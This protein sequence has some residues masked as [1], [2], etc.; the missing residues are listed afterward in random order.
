MSVVLRTSSQVPAQIG[1]GWWTVF[2]GTPEPKLD[3]AHRVRDEGTALHQGFTESLPDWRSLAKQMDGLQGQYWGH[4]PSVAPNP[5]DFGLMMAWS[6]LVQRWAVL[7]ET[8]LVV[9]DDPWMFRHFSTLP[10]VMA[11]DPPPL[12]VPRLRQ[13]VRGLL[14]RTL[15][16]WK[17][18]GAAIRLRRHKRRAR[19]GGAALLVYG[20]PASNARGHDA[21]FGSL[22]T[23]YPELGRALHVDCGV[24]AAGKLAADGR[25]FS[26]HAFGS[27]LFALTLPW[28]SWRPP[29]VLRT[30]DLAWLIRRAE[31]KEGAGGSAAMIRW[32]I[33][34]QGRWLRTCRPSV[35]VWPWENHGWERALVRQAHGQGVR[36][37]GYQHTVIGEQANIS[38]QGLADPTDTLPDYVV[39]NGPSGHAQLAAASIPA[40]RLVC[41]GT[42]RFSP[43][44]SLPYDPHGP[45]FLALPFDRVVAE[46]MIDA[47]RKASARGFVFLAKDHPLHPVQFD[48]CSG[49]RRTT[50]P[51]PQQPGVRAVVFAATAVG[52]EAV[53]SRLPTVRFLPRGCI[54]LDIL[55]KEI[56]VPNVDAERLAEVL[57]MLEPQAAIAWDEIFSAPVMDIWRALLGVT[58]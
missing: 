33:H 9:C 14:A 40:D 43:T 16:T 58:R 57:E 44:E 7:T 49:V 25:S 42:F 8:V 10:G 34:C 35:V 27:P 3:P 22:M 38:A 56:A 1:D 45:V 30:G 39:S 18:V 55:P 19:P 46:Q 12:I 41:G 31:A 28:L 6:L 13:W 54:A 26:L 48:D 52:L 37:V 51:L 36:T 20:H 15:V 50:V 24:D 5:S 2:P 17:V 4:V 21:Y 53:L 11:G 32:Q 23:E 29:S 47:A